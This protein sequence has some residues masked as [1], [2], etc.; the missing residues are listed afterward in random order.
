[1]KKF[2][3]CFLICIS[4]IFSGCS[5]NTECVHLDDDSNGN[6]DKCKVSVLS[7]I[8]FY[9]INDLHGKFA[10]SDAQPGVDN[11]TT[12]L[13]ATEDTDDASVFLSAGD[14]WQGSAES[15]ST[16]GLVI[17]D[18]MNELDFAAMTLGNHEY[19]WGSEAI[20]LNAEK[21]EFPILAINVYDKSTNQR[22]DYAESSVLIEEGGIQIG[23]IGAIGDCYSS[24]AP[25]Q[26]EDV[27]FKVGDDLTELVKAESEMLREMGADIIVYSLHDG[28]GNSKAGIYDI[29]A[30]ELDSYYDVELSNG[31]VDL[32]FEG[33]THQKY[34]CSDRYDVYHLQSGG[35]NDGISHVEIAY[36]T[37]NDDI[38]VNTVE[39]LSSDS[40]KDYT[41]D[42]L[43]EDI[44]GNYE[45]IEETGRVVGY[46]EY[47]RNG[48]HLRQIAANK[49]YEKGVE[50]WGDKYDVVLGGGFFSVRSPYEIPVGEVT[51]ADIQTIF[52]F[53]NELVL[54]SIKGS[55]LLS[56]FLNSRNDNYFIS[57]KENL[58]DS[59]DPDETYYIVV[60]SYTSSYAP[61]KLTEIEYYGEKV[62]ARDFLAEYFE[63]ESK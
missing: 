52:P 30:F 44:M 38:A 61:N 57:C 23:I 18:W 13:K 29:S 25:Y 32:V 14:M 27:Y 4:L 19:D 60:D 54:C 12:F 40:Y 62:Y 37:V 56:R 51:Y 16:Q 41:S 36:N 7:V 33:H 48:K 17:T 22:V 3:I 35:D 9:A 11:L 59:I 45:Q 53:D 5:K 21:A 1:M 42:P 10:D 58:K 2:L 26:V 50:R 8:D 47:H 63:E 15:N 43:I 24:I 49:Y 34:I 20:R 39:F 31:Y 28:Y 55:N 6:C 46:N